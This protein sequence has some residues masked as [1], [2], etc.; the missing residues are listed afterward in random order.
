MKLRCTTNCIRF[1]IRRSELKD[2][3]ERGQLQD[4]VSFPGGTQFQFSLKRIDAPSLALTF[5]D[6]HLA[7]GIPNS[8]VKQWAQPQE[9]GFERYLNLP[10]GEQVHVL[11]EKDFPC[12]HRPHE[13]KTDTF[14]ELSVRKDKKPENDA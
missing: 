6:G 10:N 7:V 8:L 2:F 12:L 1:R 4:R 5:R 11:I 13:D 3:L 14:Q 9:V